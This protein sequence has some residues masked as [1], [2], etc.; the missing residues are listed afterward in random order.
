MMRTLFILIASLLS[1]V[2]MAQNDTQIIEQISAASAKITTLECD[3]V[4]TKH[5]KILDNRLV[6]RGKMYYSQPDK[7]RW[8]YVTPYSYI[9]IMNQN[10]ILL[11]NSSR[12]DVIDVNQNKIFKDISRLMMNSIMGDMLKDNTTFEISMA[13]TKGGYTATLIPIKREMKQMWTKL[14]LLFD[15]ESLG[16]KRME[17]HEKSGDCTII[18]LEN[19]KINRAIN[20][21][22]FN[23]Q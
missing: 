19:V 14:V 4:Q 9:F 17:M 15:A 12:A 23:L 5:L 13:S 8:E 10:Q 18:E 6:S 22:L 21:T 20:S 2:A 11:K 16:V 7:L 3:F 1:C